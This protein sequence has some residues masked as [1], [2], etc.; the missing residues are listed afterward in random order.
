[1][2]SRRSW[3]LNGGEV[4]VGSGRP[5][6]PDGVAAVDLRLGSEGSLTATADF[7]WPWVD[8]EVAATEAFRPRGGGRIILKIR[9]DSDGS[10]FSEDRTE[11]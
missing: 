7:P 4:E 3:E 2:G 11:D 9:F 8:P 5:S 10:V 1:M 6:R